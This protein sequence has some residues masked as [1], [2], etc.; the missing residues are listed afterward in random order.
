MRVALGL[1]GAV[2]RAAGAGHQRLLT[3][4]G[5]VPSLAEDETGRHPQASARLALESLDG[6]LARIDRLPLV[7]DGQSRHP[8][9]SRFMN[10]GTASRRNSIS[11]AAML[12]DSRSK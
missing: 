1:R 11:S 4:G 6:L 2:V 10:S 3:S 8:H 5:F 9:A 7:G 12:R